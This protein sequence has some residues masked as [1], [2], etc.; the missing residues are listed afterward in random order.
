MLEDPREQFDSESPIIIG[1]SN[2]DVNASLP[3]DNEAHRQIPLCVN[4][5]LAVI[6]HQVLAL[7]QSLE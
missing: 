7:S 3:P 6:V 2:L 4:Q 5:R 1:S